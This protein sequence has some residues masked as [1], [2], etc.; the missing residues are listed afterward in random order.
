MSDLRA[1]VNIGGEMARKLRAVGITTAEAL[2]AEG[3]MGAYL[4]L[5]V[6]YPNVCLV[7]L[8]ALEGAVRGGAFNDL[9]AEVKGELRAFSDSLR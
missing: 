1:M 4:R 5:K 8:Y 3:A 7:H 6:V 2:R 9:P